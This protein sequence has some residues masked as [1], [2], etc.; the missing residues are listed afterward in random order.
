MSEFHQFGNLP[1]EI[2]L[3]IWAYALQPINPTRLRA[4]F[5]SVTNYPEDGDALKKLRVQCFLG[6]DCEIEHGSEFCLAAPK[7]GSSHSWTDNNPSAYVWDFGMWNACCESNAVIEKHYN[8]DFWK[9]RFRQGRGDFRGQEP[10]ACV[11]FIHPRTDGDWRFSIHTNRDLVCLQPSNIDTVGFYWGHE[12]FMEDFCMVEWNKGLCGFVNLAFEYDPSWFDGFFENFNVVH[13]FEEKS[14]RGLLIRTLVAMDDDD[15][16]YLPQTVWLIDY[17]LKRDKVKSDRVASGEGK[18]FHGSNKN[19]VEVLN[20]RDYS[21]TYNLSAL[22]FL[23][24]LGIL[25]D[26]IEPPRHLCLS[27]NGMYAGCNGCDAG[28]TDEYYVDHHLQVLAC[29]DAE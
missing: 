9:A 4:H 23:D 1:T 14:P 26:G 5:F 24:H 6:S 11:P 10:D 25:L 18:V 19:F 28:G 17:N 16:V 27:H 8:L 21:G 22:D 20:A 3:K 12:Y 13:F 29:E 15:S 7:F 2:R